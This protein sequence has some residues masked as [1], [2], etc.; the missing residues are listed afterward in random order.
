M[1]SILYKVIDVAY[2][3][4]LALLIARIILSWVNIG[5][6]EIREFIFRITDPVLN[7]IRRIMPN[8]GG[9]DFSPIVVLLLAQLLKSVLQ[10]MVVRL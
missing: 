9:I 5:S 7:P 8:T 1:G 4:F 3:L 6:Y 10:W 2:W